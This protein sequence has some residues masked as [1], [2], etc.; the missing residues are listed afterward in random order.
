MYSG[1]SG[2]R[3]HQT[4]MDVVGNNIANVNTAG[5]KTS[6]TVFQDVLSQTLQGAGGPQGELGGTNP[7]QVGLGV[8]LGAISTNFSQGATQLTGRATDLAIQGDGF[9]AV[10]QGG[11]QLYTRAGSFNFDANGSLVTPQ[12]GSVLGWMAGPDGTI[13]ANGPLAPVQLPVGQT[14]AP[15]QTQ[16]IRVGGNLPDTPFQIAPAIPSTITTAITV[17]DSQGA[18]VKLSLTY[19]QTADDVWSVTATAPNSTTGVSEAV[20]AAPASITWAPATGTF[21]ATALAL[22][23]PATTGTFAGALNVQLGTP[24]E[25]MTQ[26]AGQNSIAALSQNGAAMGALQSF[27]IAPNGTVLG[28]FSN[29]VRQPVGQIAMANFTNPGGLEKVGGSMYRP[30]ANSGLVQTGSAGTGGRGLLAGGVIEMSNVDLAAEFTNLIVAQRGFQANSRIISA[31][32]ELLQ[33]L[34]NLK[35]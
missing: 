29:G 12:G 25:P 17:Y 10:Q 31:S 23:M 1:V 13:N 14:L 33:D 21:N 15:T 30:S 22:T 6:T 28:V 19:T 24:A 34:V 2:L 35:R 26:Y 20:T 8:K 3:T 7:A 32:D 11:E 9:F 18:P 27:S 16:T 4:M 5:Y